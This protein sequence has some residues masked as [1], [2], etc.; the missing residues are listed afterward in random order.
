[1]GGVIELAPGFHA[2]FT[3]RAARN[4][5]YGVG[6]AAALV[7]ANRA[8]AAA[9]FGFGAERI[10]WMNQVHGADVAVVAGPGLA[11]SVDAM[12]ST[13]PDVV[14]AALAAD[15]LPLVAAAPAAGVIAAAHSGRA[16][17]AA[18]VAT[19]MVRSMAAL[20]AAPD[21]IVVALG[22][23]ICGSCYEVPSAM[24]DEVA[25]AVPEAASLTRWGSTGVD[26]RAAVAAQ[27]RAAGVGQVIDDARCTLE[28]PELFSHRRDAPTGRMAGYVWRA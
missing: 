12:V 21:G 20:G 5:A 28:D 9:R 19:A 22:P 26:M 7:D 11:G 10:A 17:T 18:G 24:R 13:S 2:G 15:C 4:Q 14:L 27:L 3:E 6:D 1:M 8:E 23:A 25:A 16:G